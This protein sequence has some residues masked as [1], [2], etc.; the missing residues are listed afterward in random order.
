MKRSLVYSTDI[1]YRDSL[2][3]EKKRYNAKNVAE[4]VDKFINDNFRGLAEVSF[5]LPDEAEIFLSIESLA[6]LFKEIFDLVLGRALLKM[7][8][9][10]NLGKLVMHLLPEPRIECS[11]EDI[12]RIVRLARDVG[13]ELVR[14]DDRVI[15]IIDSA[16]KINYT[17]YVPTVKNDVEGIY[18][19]IEN[20]F[21]RRKDLENE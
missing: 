3:N 19:K 11:F 9:C 18:R 20:V 10:F 21:C 1:S 12:S 13:F 7:K 15:F 14:D 17:V 8:F 4:A 6:V 2:G 5:D 16:E